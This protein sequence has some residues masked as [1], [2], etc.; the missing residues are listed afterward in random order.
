MQARATCVR[1]TINSPTIIQSLT[2]ENL[3]IVLGGN[4]LS[5]FIDDTDTSLM[6]GW[7]TCIGHVEV[8]R[9]DGDVER[10]YEITFQ[11][12]REGTK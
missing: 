10:Q 1:E 7:T 6:T 2:T 11:L 12:D 9:A 8:I 5:L 3:G 4:R